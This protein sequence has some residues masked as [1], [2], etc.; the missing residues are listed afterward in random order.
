ME[1]NIIRSVLL[2]LSII[3]VFE[4]IMELQTFSESGKRGWVMSIS[5]RLAKP[6]TVHFSD[7]PLKIRSPKDL[8]FPPEPDSLAEIK[9]YYADTTIWFEN[10]QN[11]PRL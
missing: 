5:Q 8:D 4:I 3:I 1:T 10:K 7:V 11:S 2:I 6:A 9:N